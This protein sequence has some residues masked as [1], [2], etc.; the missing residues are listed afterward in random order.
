[1]KAFAPG[2][3]SWREDRRLEVAGWLLVVIGVILAGGL[4]L[5]AWLSY[6]H[7]GLIDVFG[8]GEDSP[9]TIDAADFARSWRLGS[10]TM[11][12]LTSE[13]LQL[14]ELSFG[15]HCLQAGVLIPAWWWARRRPLPST[16]ASFLAW[17]ALQGAFLRFAPLDFERFSGVATATAL[18]WLLALRSAWRYRDAER[19]LPPPS[20][21]R[22]GSPSSGSP[23]ARPPSPTTWATRGAAWP[24]RSPAPSSRR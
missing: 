10:T 20:V 11:R 14:A 5:G 13:I 3:R 1:M 18:A 15:W 22:S 23:A 19:A 7:Y 2:S 9:L 4:G 17:I 24:R 6:V 21:P 12:A 8:P 16:I